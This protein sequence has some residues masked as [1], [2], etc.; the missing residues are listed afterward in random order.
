MGIFDFW[1]KI[2]RNEKTKEIEK[3]KIAFSEIERRV[4]N[5]RKEIEIKDGKI[6]VL[7]RERINVLINELKIKMNIV[8]NINVEQ[9]KAED[10]IKSVVEEGRKKYV[11]S[12]ESLINNLDN[13]QRDK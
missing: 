3:E 13:L 1:R 10:K 6:F 7:I 2:T 12:V 9:K 11:E 8:K 4:E 5:K